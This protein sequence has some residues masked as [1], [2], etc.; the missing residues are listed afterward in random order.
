QA[1]RTA[2]STLLGVAPARAWT[3]SRGAVAFLAR[4]PT[5]SASS[6]RWP[7]DCT[8]PALES[9]DG[10][11]HHGEGLGGGLFGPVAGDPLAGDEL[12]QER[13]FL[14]AALDRDR[15]AGVEA[16]AA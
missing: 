3:S 4:G 12:T 10:P 14:A 7:P 8:R 15:T 13:L 16:T 9:S 5:I 2:I 11:R 1:I 6:S